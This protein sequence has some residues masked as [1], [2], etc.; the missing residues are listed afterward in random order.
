MDPNKQTLLQW[1]DRDRDE[2]IDLACALIKA[3]S[4]NPPGD[5]RRVAAVLSGVLDAKKLRYRVLAPKPDSP[6]IVA[7]FDGQGPGKSLILNGHMD[8]LPVVEGEA[9]THDPWSGVVRDGKIWGRGATN[10]KCGLAV[11]LST[12]LYLHRL[13]HDLGGSLTF[14][15]VSEEI[16]LGEH[17]TQYLMSEV[18][19]VLGDGCLIAEPSGLS[20]IRFGEKGPMRLQFHIQSTGGHGAFTH[21]GEGAIRTAAR[22]IH[23]LDS[24]KDLE[25]GAPDDVE[26]R[27]DRATDDID[28]TQG[29]G[30]SDIAQ[31]LTITIAQIQGGIAK[32]LIPAACR[33]VADIRLPLGMTKEDVMTVVDQILVGFPEV[34]VEEL[35]FNPPAWCDPEGEIAVLIR[36]NVKHLKGFEPRPIVSLG[37]TDARLWR[38]RGI[39]SYNYG[40]PPTGM[41]GIDER[42]EVDD[43]L[44]VMRTHALTAYDFLARV[45]NHEH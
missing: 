9:W 29:A 43:F 39:P 42:V 44:H 41:G 4:P 37:C 6:N 28:T 18:P 8:V 12:Y 30:A 5:T 11:A 45:Q 36:D 23:A 27:L 10:M 7:S 21:L 31:R 32:N 15:A 33:F 1:I 40:P 35:D 17:G 22:L 19:E 13:R 25:A 20:T 26:F 24:L 14:S 16:V 2:L 34:R 3:K 38:Y